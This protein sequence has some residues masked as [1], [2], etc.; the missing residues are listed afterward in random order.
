MSLLIALLKPRYHLS[1]VT[2]AVGALLFAP[3]IDGELAA[4]LAGLYISFNVL[5]YGGI[6]TFNDIADRKEDARHPIKRT[7]P[8]ASGRIGV[9]TA[10][11]IAAGLCGSGILLAV[12][13]FSPAILACYAAIAVLNAAYSCGGRS[14]AVIDVALNAAPHAI[15]LLMGALL[16]ERVAP[17]GHLAARFCLAAAIACVRRRMEKE[18][19]GEIARPVLR[20]YS[21]RALATAADGGFLIV[22]TLCILDGLSSPGFYAI[23]IPAHALFAVFA[24]RVAVGRVGLGRLWLR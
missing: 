9:R 13:L 2:V 22:L 23:I 21:P 3:A 19:G 14:I 7:R 11:L 16:V 15:R 5:L 18:S 1:F 12:A 4:K 24:P 20:R 17:F 6:Y 10:V 8:V